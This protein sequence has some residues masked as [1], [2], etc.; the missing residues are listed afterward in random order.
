MENEKLKKFIS[1]KK[2]K[3]SEWINSLEKRKI[4]EIEFH[5]LD[6]ENENEIVI[7]KQKEL[8]IH[9]N[10]K[11]YTITNSSNDYINKWLLKNVKNKVFLDYACGEGLNAIKVAK[12]GASISIG[13]DIS[14]V[15]IKIADELAKKN[16]VSDICFFLQSD[17]E[18]TE[19]PENSIDIIICSGMLHH[20]DLTF[21]FPELRRILKPGGKIICIE[22]LSVNPL[23]QLYRNMTPEM[24]TDWEK[25]HILG[26]KSLTFAKY[27]F[28]V[29]EVMYWHLF[30]ILAVPF[31]KT[32]IFKPLYFILIQFDKLFL[33]IPFFNRLSW[34][35]TFVLQKP[36]N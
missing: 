11:F 14:D 20:L 18:N 7:K 30:V 6:R 1:S 16:K 29:Q 3:P 24:R 27:F 8:D 22:A 25:K 9:A 23:I 31:R 19:L 36:N 34:Q 28:N 13:I 5:N 17:C 32:F 4:D 15:S 35:F 2:F 21:A 10:K 33:K 26:P 12:M